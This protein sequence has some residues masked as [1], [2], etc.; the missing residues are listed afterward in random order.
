MF[1]PWFARLEK[2]ITRI[3]D[4]DYRPESFS[5]EQLLV[6][7]SH[8]NDHLAT[9]SKLIDQGLRNM[10]RG[11]GH[12]NEV[13]RSL[14]GPTSIAV[15]VAHGNILIAQFTESLAS[16]L[17]QWLNNLNAVHLFAEHRQHGRLITRAR[18]DIQSNG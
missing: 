12:N 17:G 15:A 11:G 8:G 10:I 4:R 18:S 1:D 16:R 2:K 5:L 14:I 7:A 13:K 3:S 6:M 9:G